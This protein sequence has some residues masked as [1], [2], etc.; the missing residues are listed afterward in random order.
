MRRVC[1]PAACLLAALGD[2]YRLAA[3]VGP[4]AWVPGNVKVSALS[5]IGRKVC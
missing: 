3:L 4:T 1:P 5:K 2:G